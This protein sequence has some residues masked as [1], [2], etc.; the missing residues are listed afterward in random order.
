MATHKSAEKRHRQS[1]KK[2][3]RNRQAKSTLRSAIKSALTL[4]T[5]K[6]DK[7]AVTV[8]LRKATRLL[9]KAAV[10]GVLHKKTAARHISRLTKRVKSA[11]A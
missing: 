8:A 1:L 2:R 3:D 11:Q 10:H 9:D 7:D 6:G 4:A 5:E